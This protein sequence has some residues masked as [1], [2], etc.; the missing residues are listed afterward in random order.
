[1]PSTSK[2]ELIFKDFDIDF[3]T[4]FLLDEKGFLDP[5]VYDVDLNFGETY[6]YHDDWFIQFVMHQF[7][8]FGV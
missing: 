4:D 6:L 5:V 7:L 3:Q 2:V 1:M 8:Y